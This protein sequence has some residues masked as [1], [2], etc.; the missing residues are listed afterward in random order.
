MP[1]MPERRE[2][3]PTDPSSTVHVETWTDCGRYSR[4][5]LS[6]LLVKADVRFLG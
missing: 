4:Q 2:I 5:T 6:C 3:S 1:T